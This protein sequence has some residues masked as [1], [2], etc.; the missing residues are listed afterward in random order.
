MRTSLET[1]SM[2]SADTEVEFYTEDESIISVPDK[3]S[4]H[5]KALEQ[6][7]SAMHIYFE[8]NFDETDFKFFYNLYTNMKEIE[9]SWNRIG[10]DDET[11]L[12]R[13]NDFYKE[14]NSTLK[15]AKKGEDDQ[16][17]KIRKKRMKKLKK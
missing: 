13:R 8:Y 14:L 11:K 17:N 2:S 1:C 12:M 4:S 7:K 5:M 3:S 16:E 6:I 10:F 15:I 9:E